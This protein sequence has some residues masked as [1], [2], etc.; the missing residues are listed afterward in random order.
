MLLS[1]LK[2]ELKV[3]SEDYLLL[4][5]GAKIFMAEQSKNEKRIVKKTLLDIINRYNY[6]QIP[7][8]SKK[9]EY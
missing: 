6:P 3:N 1:F 7:N 5:I 2:V 9:I 8:F 4:F